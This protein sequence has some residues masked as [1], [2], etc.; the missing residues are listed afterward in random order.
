MKEPKDKPGEKLGTPPNSVLFGMFLLDKK[1]INHQVLEAALNIQK[2]E[3]SSTLRASH[4]LLGQ[5]LIDDF[6]AF[7]DR[8][9]L[10]HYLTQFNDYKAEMEQLLYDANIRK[11]VMEEWEKH[12]RITHAAF[13]NVPSPV[14]DK[15]TGKHGFVMFRTGKVVGEVKYKQTWP[16]D[17]YKHK[18]AL[19]MNDRGKLGMVNT[20]GEEVVP[21]M[22]DQMIEKHDAMLGVLRKG[23]SESYV[24]FPFKGFGRESS[25]R[26][27]IKGI[28]EYEER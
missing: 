17:E 11:E 1:K 6:H 24:P 28:F 16:F 9:E 21:L 26:S 20:D 19:V 10:S 25:K 22:F 4:R 13:S 3:D 5:I 14:E 12:Y 2:K 7:K 27:A 8:V 18:L 23:K 15:K